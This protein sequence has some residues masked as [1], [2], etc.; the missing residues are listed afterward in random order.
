M[1]KANSA[2]HKSR[3]SE[4]YLET[5]K[6]LLED[7]K[8]KNLMDLASNTWA[9]TEDIR[10]EIANAVLEY[11]GL[12]KKFDKFKADNAED[13]ARKTAAFMQHQTDLKNYER[14]RIDLAAQVKNLEEIR[15]TMPD[16]CTKDS[17]INEAAGARRNSRRGSDI[18][19]QTQSIKW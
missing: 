5:I 18:S 12:R 14:T 16:W 10:E 1:Q 3:N 17:N 2:L 4:E 11:E 15:D 9:S 19:E 6:N 13:K 7:L 8:A